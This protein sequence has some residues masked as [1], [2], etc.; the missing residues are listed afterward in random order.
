MYPTSYLN[1]HSITS[2]FLQ[3]LEILFV[4]TLN[5]IFQSKWPLLFET[6]EKILLQV[7]NIILQYDYSISHIIQIS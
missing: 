3:L 5:N 1:I 4:K 7:Q 6:S 2:V